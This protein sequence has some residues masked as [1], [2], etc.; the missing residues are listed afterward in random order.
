MKIGDPA[1]YTLHAR[2]GVPDA[3]LRERNATIAHIHDDGRLDLDV[4]LL[5]DEDRDIIV[6]CKVPM[7]TLLYRVEGIREGEGLYCY[8]LPAAADPK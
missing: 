7:D 1:F 2:R 5:K 8:R 4:A 6:E 3:P